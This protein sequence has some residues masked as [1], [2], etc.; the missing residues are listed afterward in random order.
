MADQASLY[1]TTRAITLDVLAVHGASEP[2]R[3]SKFG[4]THELLDGSLAEQIAGGRREISIDFN[5]MS[6]LQRRQVVDWWLNPD[7]EI[8]SLAGTLQNPDVELIT[9]GALTQ[10]ETY[11]FKVSAVDVI[12]EGVRRRSIGAG[13]CNERGGSIPANGGFIRMTL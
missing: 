1:T 8:R 4:V 9:G 6:T 10:G 7:R 11:Y 5:T 12:G 3:L 13:K 2:D